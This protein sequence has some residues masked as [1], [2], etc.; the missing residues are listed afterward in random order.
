MF[1]PNTKLESA[2]P[3]H[4]S[5][6]IYLLNKINIVYLNYNQF[7]F[8]KTLKKNI[9]HFF[10]FN[11]QIKRNELMLIIQTTEIKTS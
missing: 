8:R 9:S 2:N 1:V 10:L 3:H 4:K 5:Y 11:A 7:K 6:I